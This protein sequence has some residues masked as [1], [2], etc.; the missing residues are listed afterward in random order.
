METNIETTGNTLGIL[1][2]CPWPAL[3][4]TQI[5]SKVSWCLRLWG[6]SISISFQD[7]FCG[8][9][10]LYSAL[11]VSYSMADFICFTVIPNSSSSLALI[12][13]ASELHSTSTSSITMSCPNFSDSKTGWSCWPLGPCVYIQSFLGCCKFS[14]IKHKLATNTVSFYFYF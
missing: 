13:K 11:T 3:L 2:L 6:A 10:L 9:Y 12:L 4:G 14:R 1:C 7:S 5:F 8:L